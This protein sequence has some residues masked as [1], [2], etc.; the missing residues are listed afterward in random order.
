MLSKPKFITVDEEFR[1]YVYPD[2]GTINCGAVESIAVSKSGNHRV[3]CKDGKKYIVAPG[4]RYIYF[5][6]NKWSF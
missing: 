2:G 3:T 6:S 5:R 1:Q 4:W